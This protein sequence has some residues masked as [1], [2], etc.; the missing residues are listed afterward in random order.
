MTTR[1]HSETGVINTTQ[2]TATPENWHM[3]T[4]EESLRRLEVTPQQG[5]STT[6]A[7]NRLTRY[8]TNELEEGEHRTL[9][10][11]LWEQIKEPLVLL[12]IFAAVISAFLGKADNVIAIMAI[13][14]LNAAL[15]V[16]QEYRSEKAMAALRQMAAP[17]VR[18]RRDGNIQ[19]IASR[20]LVPGDIVALEAGSIIPA[21]ARVIEAYNLRVQEASLT[22]ESLPVD[23]TTRPIEREQTALGDRRSMV[24]MGTSVVYGRGEVMIT[25]TGMKT[26]LGHIATLIQSVE[27]DQ[28]PL[29]KRMAELGKVMLGASVL[30]M[31]VAFLI[32]LWRGDALSDIALTSVAIAVAVVPEG[33]PA[34]V[35]ISL[36]LGTQR[37]LRRK[38]LIRKLPAVETLGSVTVICSDKTGTLTENR[39][40]VTALSA[41]GETLNVRH[42]TPLNQ[43]QSGHTLLLMAATL[44]SDAMIDQNG[45]VVGDPTEGA[46]ITAADHAGLKKDKL[47]QEMPRT[48]EAPF[49]SERKRM[50]TVH[51]VETTQ[52]NGLAPLVQKIDTSS[53]HHIAFTKG[54][55]DGLLT[56]C[57]AIW[58]KDGVQPLTAEHSQNV[59]AEI[60]RLAGAGLRVLGVAYRTI[61]FND[62]QEGD[63]E[64]LEQDM[65]FVG[66]IGMIDPPREEV[67]QAVAVCRRAGIRPVMITGDHPLTAKAI[68]IDL[69]ITTPDAA[70]YT[71]LQLSE[72]SDEQLEDVVETVS[73]YARVSPEDKLRIVR[74]LQKRGHIAA[75]TGDGVNDAPAL[76]QADIGVAMGI[77]GTDVSKEAA[78]MVIVDDNFATIVSAAEEGRTI[79]DN[80][81]RFIKYLL[82]SNTGELFVLLATQLIAGMTMPLTT[83][84]ILWMNLITDGIPA[85]AL[86]LEKAEKN[87]MT[88]APYA[89]N[90][91][92]FGRGLGRHILIVGGLLGVT[93][94][95]FGYWAWSTEIVAANGAPAWN[96]MVF[97][98]L[99]MAQMG[100]A[101][102]VRSH[103]ESLFSMNL[104]SNPILIGAVVSTLILQLIA[105]YAPFFNDLFGTNPL[106]VEQLALCLVLSTIVF[107]GVELEKLLIR[108]GVLT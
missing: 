8:G 98:L 106:T 47:N 93:S 2:A 39:M 65:V 27:S 53:T 25:D 40:T 71:G 105:V 20:D 49:S 108:R 86:G 44:A 95:A 34:V 50:T 82:A 94:L 33:L 43:M 62:G 11:A 30:I 87:A 75:M 78:D 57:N 16:F 56:I 17:F 24:Y 67:K 42:G 22:G 83:L 55:G 48:A 45:N 18:V 14:I 41:D 76:R 104:F 23:K 88:R 29:Q 70:V 74:A 35:T 19:D 5:L 102:G 73:V 15:G 85:L 80:V 9:W 77:T 63:I 52:A 66:L 21:D 10:M 1:S 4:A 96:T 51:H 3:L 64:T 28:T 91:S 90:E 26:Q 36:A 81:R 32:G 68:A 31:L 89:P 7:Q 72:L 54:A 61:E 37:M 84:Q 46:I 12:L 59:T 79:Y 38:A 69:N 58:T 13:V 97:M 101:L 6:E 103:T 107:W 92:V 60:D 100:H 99:T